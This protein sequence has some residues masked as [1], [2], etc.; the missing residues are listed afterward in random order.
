MDG[1]KVG[2]YHDTEF[3][4]AHCGADGVVRAR[5]GKGSWRRGKPRHLKQMHSY[6][7]LYF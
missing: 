4:G 1:Q 6:K 2:K 5:V 7:E 3:T